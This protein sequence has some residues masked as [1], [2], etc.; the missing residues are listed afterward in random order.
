MKKYLV[1]TRIQSKIEDQVM[2]QDLKDKD[3]TFKKLYSSQF[4]SFKAK[5]SIN[6]ICDFSPQNIGLSQQQ[7]DDKYCFF[8]TT[9]AFLHPVKLVSKRV[10][11]EKLFGVCQIMMVLLS[12]VVSKLLKFRN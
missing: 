4:G 12:E 9:F 7:N 6:L 11:D 1:D 5:N 2:N 10:S 3:W 8:W